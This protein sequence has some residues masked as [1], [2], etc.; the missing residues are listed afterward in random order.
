M[1]TVILASRI[2]FL[3]LEPLNSADEDGLSISFPGSKFYHFENINTFFKISKSGKYSAG[4]NQDSC[5]VS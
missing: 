5:V 3:L 4:R 2:H 1:P